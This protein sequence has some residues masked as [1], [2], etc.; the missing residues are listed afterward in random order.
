M[1]T[2]IC[3]TSARWLA[4]AAILF[5]CFASAH[6]QAASANSGAV[7]TVA[8]RSND[9]VRLDTLQVTGT[10]LRSQEAVN[11]RRATLVVAD[12]LTQ[13]DLGTLA[14]ENLADAMIRIPGVSTMQ[15]LYGEQEAS[16]VST[17]G[18]S[19]DLNFVSFDGISMFSTANDG[20][21]L[22]RVDLNLIPTQIS[23][24]TS[25]YKSFT[26]DMDAG[27]IGG[28]I[29]IEP[30]SAL[31]GRE[32]GHI[33]GQIVTQTASGKY[34]PGDNSLGNYR[35]Q[36]LGG[37]AKGLWVKRFGAESRFG[38]V[39]SGMYHQRNYDYTKRNP[40][41]R[42][43]YTS[44]GATAAANLSNW[45][46]L[47]PFPTLIRPMDY[48][49]YTQTHGGSAQFEYRISDAWQVSLLGFGYKQVE[50]QNL[51]MFYVET[52]TGLTRPSPEEGRFRI[53]RTRPSF[54]YDRFQQETR[55]VIF[56]AIGKFG[57]DSSLEL[58][59]S[60][61]ANEFYDLDLT[62]IYAFN[63]PAS[64]ITF[65]MT[66][67]VDQF[68][69]ENYGPLADVANYQ[70]SSAEDNTVRA[71]V[72]STE[73]RIDFKKNFSSQS[74]GFGFM[75]GADLRETKDKRDATNVTFVS[76]SGRLTD[77]GFVPSFSSNNYGYP[78]VWINY[79]KYMQTVKPGLAINRATSNNGSWSRDYFYQE[80]ILAGYF[81]AKY[82]TERTS[83]IAGVRYDRVNFDALSPESI[84]G[85]FIGSFSP[86]AGGYNHLLPSVSLAH[87]LTPGLRLKAGVS[88]S[89][90]RPQ[91]GD[92]A[93]AETRNQTNLTISRGNA[94]LQPRQA[95]NY[96]LTLEYYFAGS[97]LASVGAFYKNIKDDIYT[98]AAEETIDGVAYTVTTPRNA[99]ASKMR[100]VEAQIIHDAI[101]GLP[102]FLEKRLGV[103]LNYTKLWGEM[104]YLS[105][106][107]WVHLKALQYQPDWMANAT[108]F[109]SL[110]G[111]RGEIRVSYHWKG[112]SPIS[113]GATPWTTYWLRAQERLDVGIRYS[114]TRRLI[115]KLQA[116]NLTSEPV[117]Q[118]YLDPYAMNRYEMGRDKTFSLDLTYKL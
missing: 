53:G 74:T 25:V 22:R 32:T 97:G 94:K 50:D 80:R 39:L 117:Q 107:T 13:D 91:F 7:P 113:L 12:T 34:V 100:G 111:K 73:A 75:V 57:A 84:A 77:F 8:P 109:Y 48:T 21:G 15:T 114:L 38:V 88:Q 64:F 72:D 41:G 55:G 61:F 29:N 115:V 67:L 54:S 89:L 66:D 79:E 106:A 92:I 85:T 1:K 24:R 51:N 5:S 83:A 63:P 14:D 46:G 76:N 70:M 102:G 35:D 9:V 71:R 2:T 44:T 96:D 17:R 36:P 18:I 103:S 105:G 40:N 116:N 28:V 99:S 93:Q 82:G 52:F 20:D 49:H 118:G 101:P 65:N 47:H 4:G 33:T 110:P 59:A 104:D 16:Y 31:N 10:A 26:A 69:I 56:K 81:S 23:R 43:F 86:H 19:P 98:Q 37:G 11:D 42:I 6:A 58:R 68:S 108:V 30:Y 27:A 78:V 60:R 45:D 62:T 90:G 112:H 95:D 3:S 87:F